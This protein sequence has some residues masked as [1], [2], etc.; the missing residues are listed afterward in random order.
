MVPSTG[1]TADEL[2]MVIALYDLLKIKNAG[3]IDAGLSGEGNGEEGG[4]RRGTRQKQAAEEEGNK[5]ITGS[6][7]AASS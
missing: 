1:T 5:R 3:G 6:A 4:R 2:K 7:I